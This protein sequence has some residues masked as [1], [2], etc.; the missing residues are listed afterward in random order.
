MAKMKKIALISSA[1]LMSTAFAF[2]VAACNDEE[3]AH[4]HSFGESWTTDATHHWY[5]C[6]TDCTTTVGKAEH[7]WNDGV[8]TVNGEETVTCVVC[9]YEKQETVATVLAVG[10]DTTVK[11]A[12][13][14]ATE[15]VVGAEAGSYT[16]SWTNP[17]TVVKVGETEYKKADSEDAEGYVGTADL[18]WI[19]DTKD[20]KITVATTDGSAA[21]IVVSCKEY[22]APQLM[23]YDYSAIMA[24]MTGDETPELETVASGERGTQFSIYA[25]NPGWYYVCGFAEDGE[26]DESTPNVI[27]NDYSATISVSAEKAYTTPATVTEGM[28]A[29]EVPANSVIDVVIT[30]DASAAIDVMAYAMYMIEVNPNATGMNDTFINSLADVTININPMF[31]PTQTQELFVPM[32]SRVYGRLLNVVNP[33][34]V[35]WNSSNLVFDIAGTVYTQ[36]DCPVKVERDTFNPTGVYFTAYTTDG[37][38]AMDMITFSQ[39]PVSE[40]ALGDQS[41]AVD[42][43]S[44]EAIKY[45][46]TATGTYTFTVAN[47]VATELGIEQISVGSQ[48]AFVSPDSWY[49]SDANGE[50]AVLSI[51]VAKGSEIEFGVFHQANSAQVVPFNVSFTA[52]A[53]SVASMNVPTAT[54]SASTT[55]NGTDG[56]FYQLTTLAAGTYVLSNLEAVEANAAQGS[57]NGAIAKLYINGTEYDSYAIGQTFTLLEDS[58]VIVYTWLHGAYD[59]DTWTYDPAVLVGDEYAQVT[60]TLEA[61]VAPVAAQLGENTVATMEEYATVSYYFTATEA[62]NYTISIPDDLENYYY[63]ISD[64]DDMWF[65]GMA[66]GTLTSTTTVTLEAGQSIFFTVNDMGTAA[67]SQTATFTITKNA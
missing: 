60:I 1:I 8:S 66:R 38:P 13:G 25:Q 50:D 36:E 45:V 39:A 31:Q 54:E 2:G 24:M 49:L 7:S 46:A 22:S 40:I 3:A 21:D 35:S 67:N 26:D 47:A 28:V 42:P 56:K 62:G 18:L 41:V 44:Y 15:I 59:D 23:S 43:S 5:A 63:N 27:E 58:E 52:M 4:V 65:L 64:V 20:V 16:I 19:E 11:V 53:S 57:T 34:Q 37:Q 29:I 48:T 51:T 6:G 33:V 30:H 12:A 14:A 61:G 9:G 55:F 10:E 32:A 17:K